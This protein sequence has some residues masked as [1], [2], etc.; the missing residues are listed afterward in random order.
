MRGTYRPPACLVGLELA[1]STRV[2]YRS[3]RQKASAPR[4]RAISGSESHGGEGQ[5]PSKRLVMLVNVE[6]SRLVLVGTRSDQKIG[7]RYA[8]LTVCRELALSGQ[9]DCDRLG[10]HSKPMERVKLDLELLEGTRRA[11]AAKHLESR[12][13]AQTRLPVRVVDVSAAHER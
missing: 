13:R 7:D 12:D 1:G 6:H 10:V 3:P 2:G 4:L 9:R 8:M 5:N 11:G